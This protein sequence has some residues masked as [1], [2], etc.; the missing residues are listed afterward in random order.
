[1]TNSPEQSEYPIRLQKYLA[2]AGVASRRGSEK[3][4]ATGKVTVNG[5]VV[6][7]LGSKLVS[8]ADVVSVNGHR[9]VLNSTQ[10]YLMLNKPAGCLTTMYDPQGRPI[11]ADLLPKQHQDGLFP[12]GRLDFDTTG[13]LLFMTDGELA[14]RLLHPSRHVAKRYIAE[15][16]GVFTEKDAQLLRRGVMLRD[17]MTKPAV[18][19]I[20]SPRQDARLNDRHLKQQKRLNTNERVKKVHGELPTVQ[21]TVEITITEGR[22][23]QIKRML[24]HIGRPVLKLHREAFGPL[25][26]GRLHL[27]E[28]RELTDAEVAALTTAGNAG[29]G[30]AVRSDGCVSSDS[31]ADTD[32]SIRSDSGDGNGHSISSGDASDISAD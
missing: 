14:H 20:L 26:L 23:R 19:R 11:V 5:L 6:T 17:G 13:L 15:V 27:G 24:S 22:K 2:R 21:T 16:D 4:I 3:L 18:V 31:S 25:E 9:V 10:S 29:N 28:C 1:M 8:P 7:Q 32:R 12:V 30:D